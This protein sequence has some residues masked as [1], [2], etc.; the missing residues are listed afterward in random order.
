MRI[1]L[2]PPLCGTFAE[3]H[4]G[5][6]ALALGCTTATPP[7][8]G[9]RVKEK[10]SRLRGWPKLLREP[11]TWGSIALQP[12]DC[13]VAYSVAPT[14]I[15]ERFSIRPT[16]NCFGDL[17][18]GQFRLPSEP[19]PASLGAPPSLIGPSQDH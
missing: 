14:D 11:L 16:S 12:A 19:N 5:M 10:A 3:A 9:R 1:A 13:R 8:L 15:S 4:K 17:E 2:W 7:G 18:G 6:R